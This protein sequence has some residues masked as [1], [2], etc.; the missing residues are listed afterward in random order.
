M[1][2]AGGVAQQQRYLQAADI[3][4]IAGQAMGGGQQLQSLFGPKT[5]GQSIANASWA[6]V[7]GLQGSSS[8]FDKP[9]FSW[10]GI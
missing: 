6:N 5:Y 2:T 1:E 4:G 3:F 9:Q 8:F 7:S 10:K